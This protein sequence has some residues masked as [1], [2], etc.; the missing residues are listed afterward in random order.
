MNEN[1]YNLKDM[2]AVIVK[3][4]NITDKNIEIIEK[5]SKD[6]KSDIRNID[7]VIKDNHSSRI[8]ENNV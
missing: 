4:L 3:A 6:L 7:K 2:L 1:V 5:A 8:E